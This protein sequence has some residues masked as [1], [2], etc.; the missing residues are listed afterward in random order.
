MIAGY[1]QQGH[2]EDAFEVYIQEAGVIPNTITYLSI[3]SACDRSETNEPE[4]IIHTRIVK[5]QLESHIPVGN[6]LVSMYGRCGNLS[7]AAQVFNKMQKQDLVS[8]NLSKA[9]QYSQDGHCDKM[10]ELFGRMHRQ[11]MEPDKVT[12]SCVL[13]A[14]ISLIDLEEGKKLHAHVARSGVESNVQLENALTSI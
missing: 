13:G 8:W 14:C 3:L 4:E 6:A 12:L 9:A 2:I 10:L 11:G 7:K 5:S 1:A